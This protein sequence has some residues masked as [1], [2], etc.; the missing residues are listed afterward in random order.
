M[1]PVVTALHVERH[2]E[3]AL[4]VGWTIDGGGGV[5]GEL[6]VA[7]GSTPIVEDHRPLATVAASAGSVRLSGL[8]AGRHYISVSAGGDTLVG[9]ERRLV[10]EGIQ[11]FRDVGGY[12]TVD[13]GRVRWGQVYRADN[14]HKLTPADLD[15]FEGLGIK[16]I[17]DLRGDT[18]RAET[19][20]PFDAV[21]TPIVGRPGGV[22]PERPFRTVADG[23]Q[24]LRDVYVGSLVHSASRFGALF[25]GLA[26][27]ARL[28]VVFHCH[29]GKDRTG[30]V[31]A[32]LLLALGVDRE[33]VLDD[34]EATSR[35]RRID[36]QQDSLT[37][38]LASGVSPEAAGAV[39]GTPRWAME[40]A[41][42]DI[43]DTYGGI[44]AYL[45]GPVGMSTVSL[46]RLRALHVERTPTAASR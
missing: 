18:E 10:F 7:V 13:G 16:T 20:G 34:Y 25:E 30:I 27:A 12:V 31:A 9:A 6:V 23:E 15:A 40:A 3:D 17:F 19:P 42:D 35:Y 8:G 14:L 33:T 36:H 41:V 11:N 1:P 4:I 29:G 32:L 37:K 26:D 22:A 39:L 5:D 28:P 43:Q 46:D 45:T 21:A 24:M 38:L 44:E 2:D